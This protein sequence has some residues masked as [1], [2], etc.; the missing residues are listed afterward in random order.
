MNAKKMA[1][2]KLGATI[3]IM[4]LVGVIVA[5]YLG[6]YREEEV[7]EL[8][9]IRNNDSTIVAYGNETFFIYTDGNSLYKLARIN[10]KENSGEVLES[11]DVE[12]KDSRIHATLNLIFY[13]MYGN[14]YMY[15]YNT[16]KTKLFQEGVLQ[17][18]QDN[19]YICLYEGS[20]YKGVFYPEGLNTHTF[21]PITSSA[22]V[23]KIHEDE[24]NLYYTAT[25][26]KNYISLFA[27]E[28]STV[29]LT[30]YDTLYGYDEK[31]VAAGS[32]EKYVYEL[33]QSLDDNRHMLRVIEK[34]DKTNFIDV[35]LDEFENFEFFPESYIDSKKA[36]NQNIYIEAKNSGEKANFYVYN[37]NKDEVEKMAVKQIDN[38]SD[39]SEYRYSLSFAGSG[40]V[41]IYKD[42][43]QFVNIDLKDYNVQQVEF[44]K[45]YKIDEE[46]YFR[47]YLEPEKIRSII[48]KVNKDGKSK[49]FEF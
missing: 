9:E 8:G 22:N 36:Y 2:L 13:N 24:K 41:T 28:K 38:L 31:I 15:D 14:T 27:I 5:T 1:L 37:I 10:E 4:I 32:N 17:Y 45:I 33:I 39:V 43:I 20:L 26:E 23:I 48:I 7:V 42:G 40:D 30:V 3:L 49:V 46:M 25:S 21:K 29:R 12:Y 16:K 47:I 35:K 18:I 19:W 34:D 44:D 6:I 11:R